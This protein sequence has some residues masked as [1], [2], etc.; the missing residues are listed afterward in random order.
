MK[1][2]GSWLIKILAILGLLLSLSMMIFSDISI[3]SSNNRLLAKTVISRVVNSSE[4]SELALG[5]NILESSGLEDELLNSLPKKT[6]ISTTPWEVYQ[7][8]SRFQKDTTLTAKDLKLPTKTA[9]ERFISKFLVAGFNEEFKSDADQ[10]KQAA[11]SYQMAFYVILLCYLL[12]AVFILLGKRWAGIFAFLASLGM[13]GIG[14]L[15]FDKVNSVLATEIYSGMKVTMNSSFN[16]GVV[17]S[18]LVMIL[19]FILQRKHKKG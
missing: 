9:G 7:M 3:T 6:V 4:S 1:I 18:G 12:S 11:R 5:Q 10:I 8:S 16:L 15:A 17:V 2:L 13:V 14:T 19:F